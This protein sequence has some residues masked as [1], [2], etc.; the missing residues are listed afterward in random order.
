MNGQRKPSL[1]KTKNREQLQLFSEALLF[2][3][4]LADIRSIRVIEQVH[5]LVVSSTF[6]IHHTNGSVHTFLDI[7]FARISIPKF[8]CFSL[9]RRWRKRITVFIVANSSFSIFRNSQF[10]S[11]VI[12]QD[13]LRK[14]EE[15]FR[16]FKEKFLTSFFLPDLPLVNQKTGQLLA[17]HEK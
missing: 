7:H 11:V 1:A 5:L 6:Y 12:N 15:S 4:Y 9:Q 2:H 14:R 16:Y 13:D 10:S 8:G 3:S 17:K